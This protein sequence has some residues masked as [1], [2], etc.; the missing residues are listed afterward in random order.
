LIIF[1]IYKTDLFRNL[2]FMMLYPSLSSVYDLRQTHKG[3][4]LTINVRS[5]TLIFL[6]IETFSLATAE[7]P[8]S[9][10]HNNSIYGINI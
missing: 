3:K 2:G 6:P 5:C 10:L 1:K 8:L 4:Y 7:A 9:G